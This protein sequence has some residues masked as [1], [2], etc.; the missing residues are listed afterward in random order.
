MSDVYSY[1]L[2]LSR[3]CSSA[4]YALGYC[5]CEAGRDLAR[6]IDA[7]R[8][9]SDRKIETLLIEAGAQP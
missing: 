1:R 3:R 4:C 9:E 8:K 2:V 6:R 7:I 5:D